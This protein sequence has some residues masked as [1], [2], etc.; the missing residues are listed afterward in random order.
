MRPWYLTFYWHFVICQNSGK[1]CGRQQGFNGAGRL[2]G[3]VLDVNSWNLSYI[4]LPVEPITNHLSP[5]GLQ[6]FC[7]SNV[8]WLDTKSRP[9][10][11]IDFESPGSFSLCWEKRDGKRGKLGFDY[12]YDTS[13]MD[14]PWINLLI[15]SNICLYFCPTY[16]T[17][18][19]VYL[20]L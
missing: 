11:K 15:A 8:L 16:N 1:R 14:M 5:K 2:F 3:K 19:N 17:T 10:F 12:T 7:D 20:N 4:S 18:Q 6:K 13:Q 9:T